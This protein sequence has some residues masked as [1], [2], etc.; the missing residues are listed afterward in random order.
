V[1]LRVAII[2]AGLGGLALAQGL[3]RGGFDVAVYERDESLAARP[4][5]YRLHLDRQGGEALQQCLP[6]GLIALVRATSGQPSRAVTVLDR[7]LRE[8]HRELTSIVDPWA[9]SVDRATLREALCRG[10]DVHYGQECVGFTTGPDGVMAH[11]ATGGPVRADV[12]V[13]ADGVSSAVRRQYLPQASLLDTGQPIIYGRTRLDPQTRPLVPPAMHDGFT[14]IVDGRVGVATGL[15]EF[16]SP[17]D[18]Y[19]LSP[20]DDYLMWAVTPPGAVSAE[21]P[22]ALHATAL[23]LLRRWHPDLQQLV[24]R[25][26]VEQTFLIRVRVAEP[27]PP[28]IPSRVTVLGDAIHAMS[29]ARGSGANTA[30]R[31]AA[32]LARELQAGH[33]TVESAIGVY[34]AQMRGYGF[35]AVA[36]SRAAE[37]TMGRR[38]YPWLRWL[39][40]RRPAGRGAGAEP[41]PA[42]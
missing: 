21:A 16:R 11:F 8:R 10:L 2:G 32:L 38:R 12:L 19:G 6:P 4:Q 42:E 18:V 26:E 30:L 29:P 13:G 37:G 17:P 33:S 36:A 39:P 14:A 40:R 27:V 15:V 25:A 41:V 28:W 22:V 34:E 3:R 23:R 1:T 20:A 5:G 24:G 31:D 35:A 7:R 9:G